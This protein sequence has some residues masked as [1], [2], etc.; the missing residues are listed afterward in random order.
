MCTGRRRG[1]GAVTL[2]V[3][4]ALALIT[5]AFRALGPALPRVPDALSRRT[6]GLAPA[7][8]AALVVTQVVSGSGVP[9]LDAKAAGVAAALV[10]AALRAPV[11][12]S[13]VGGAAVAA[14]VRVLS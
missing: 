8:L 1:S 5:F 11:G 10:L 12:L 2:A 9:V 13:V 3:V 6:T 7:L 4:G 14:L